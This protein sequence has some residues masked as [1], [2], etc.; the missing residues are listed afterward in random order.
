MRILFFKIGALGDTLMTT[1]LLRQLKRNFA[2]VKIDYLIG[3][4][5]AQSLEGNKNIH[6][7]IK[8]DEN[9]F[10]KKQIFSYFNLIR[11]IKKKK[12][13]IVFVL[14][15]HKIFN[16]TSKLFSIPTRIGFDRLGKEG[17]FLTKKVYYGSLKHEIDYYLNLGSKLIKIDYSNKKLDFFLD[18]TELKNIKL[19]KKFTVLINAGGNNIGEKTNLRSL[20]DKLFSN[21]VKKITRKQKVI[22]LGSKNEQNYYATFSNY[23]TTNLAGKL[24]LKQSAAVLKKAQ[25]IITTD[26]GLMHLASAVNKNLICIFG[27]TNPARK[28]PPNSKTIWKDKKIYNEE[29]ELFGAIPKEIFFKKKNEIIKDI[30]SL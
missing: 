9:I 10:F 29:Y 21:I 13:D 23:K 15:K 14:D 1:P 28:A 20:P 4:F 18:G 27:P 26:S 19:P 3:K 5:S 8:F 12:Y 7:I 17:I 2:N 11:K 24:S 30:V 6:N 16:F 25:K 22:F